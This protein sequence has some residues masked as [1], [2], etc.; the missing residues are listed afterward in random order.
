[1]E[2]ESKG[3]VAVLRHTL[4][5]ERGEFGVVRLARWVGLFIVA[6]G[7][8]LAIWTLIDPTVGPGRF[9]FDARIRLFLIALSTPAWTGVAIILLAEFVDRFRPLESSMPADAP[10]ASAAQ[11]ERR[12]RR[13]EA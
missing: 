2:Q 10:E 12:T 13:T 1:M 7:I 3:V 4:G 5:L 6:S 8:V 11:R 9:S